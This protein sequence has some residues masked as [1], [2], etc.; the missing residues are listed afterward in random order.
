MGWLRRLWDRRVAAALVA[1]AIGCAIGGGQALSS[2]EDELYKAAEHV[3]ALYATHE[4]TA[5]AGGDTVLSGGDLSK[6]FFH[7]V[8]ALA[9][10]GTTFP[11]DPI[12]AGAQPPIA[13]IGVFPD[14]ETGIVEN[15]GFVVVRF[16][17]SE[18]SKELTYQVFQTG[19]TWRVVDIR[20]D[21]WTLKRLL[22]GR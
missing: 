18:E 14:T 9:M 7:P 13:D 19:E 5:G 8:T 21:D 3:A 4:E 2:E 15:A 1:A 20:G 11:F 6:Q 22:I 10:Q 16:M 12:Y 17:A